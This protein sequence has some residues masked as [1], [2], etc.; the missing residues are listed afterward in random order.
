[1]ATIALFV[2]R[3]PTQWMLMRC[4]HSQMLCWAVLLSVELIILYSKLEQH[5][6]VLKLYVF[7]LWDEEGAAQYCVNHALHNFAIQ[8][9]QLQSSQLSHSTVHS[10]GGTEVQAAANI[11]GGSGSVAP[12]GTAA[13]SSTT[14]P[15]SSSTGDDSHPGDM[16]LD[17][18]DIY[19][20]SAYAELSH[21]RR[22]LRDRY[23]A[24]TNP[25]QHGANSAS[26][27]ANLK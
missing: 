18:L 26:L 7:D 22:H 25:Q 1:M 9:Q 20:S 24:T 13:S 27:V 21:R 16:F 8:H 11:S 10:A 2:V 6:Q 12:L 23:S 19:F 5:V 3:R 17:L 14:T 15:S 4:W